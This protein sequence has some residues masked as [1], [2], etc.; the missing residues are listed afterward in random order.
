MT[1]ST[2]SLDND[3]EIDDQ[4]LL[5]VIPAF[6]EEKTIGE[7][8]RNILREVDCRVVVV[9][10][11]S[12]DDTANVARDGGA[13]I[14][15]LSVRMGS[16]GATQT[17]LRYA[18]KNSYKLVITMD[19]D[20]QHEARYIKSLVSFLTSRSIDVA[21]GSYVARGSPLR[22]IAWLVMK[23]ASGLKLEDLTSGFRVYNEEAVS[24]LSGWQATMLEYQDL[25]VLLLLQSSGMKVGDFSVTMLPRKHGK[26]QIFYSWL[27]VIRYMC[28]TVLLGIAKRRKGL[29]D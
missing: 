10:D 4:Q 12:T 19:A 15:P 1:E 18:K 13:K 20:G 11:A 26:S 3:T 27:A 28:H 23:A 14:I 9:D 5:V 25:G 8:V 2:D 29:I 24:I 21:I 7:V 22:R 16:W 6:N 17:G